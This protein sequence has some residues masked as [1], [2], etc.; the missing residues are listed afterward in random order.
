MSASVDRF[1]F[2]RGKPTSHLEV[3]AQP[4]EDI[5]FA[6]FPLRRAQS[7]DRRQRPPQIMHRLPVRVIPAG[8]LG[9]VTEI[10]HRSR[11]IP[12]GLEMH[13]QVRRL[14]GCPFAPRCDIAEPRCSAEEPPIS[15]QN[16][17]MAVCH[18]AEVLVKA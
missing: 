1:D 11:P 16:R 10:V 12:R 9:G 14:L 2:C 5:E 17:Q 6:R 8:S 18:R 15:W 3:D 7:L 4:V 13:R